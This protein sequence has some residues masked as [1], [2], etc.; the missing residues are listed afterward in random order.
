[1]TDDQ[2]TAAVTA[3]DVIVTWQ[4]TALDYLIYPNALSTYT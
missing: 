4:T 1:M 2:H 3:L